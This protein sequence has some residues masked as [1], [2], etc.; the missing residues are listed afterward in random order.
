VLRSKFHPSRDYALAAGAAVAFG[1][2]ALTISTVGPTPLDVPVRAAIHG[3]ASPVLTAAMKVATQLGGGWFLYPLGALIVG[4]LYRAGRRRESALFAVAVLGA[5]LLDQGM[6]LVFHRP[7]P[8][9]W[10]EYPQP[11]SFSFPSGHSFVS[12]CFYFS[13]AEILIEDEWPLGRRLAMWAAAGAITLAIGFSRAYL[14][15]HYPTDV[16]AGYVAAIAWTTLIR[17]AHHSYYT[18]GTLNP[19]DDIPSV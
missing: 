5:N 7:R 12:F 15:V 8:I 19:N 14:G 17:V 9:P 18:T 3:L 16:L 1:W 6:K 10:F 13:L 4:T 2:L 11:D